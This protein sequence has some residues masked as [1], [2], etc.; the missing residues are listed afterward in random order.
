MTNRRVTDL[1]ETTSLDAADVLLVERVDANVTRKA[2]VATVAG[3]VGAQLGIATL[4]RI[5]SFD[6]FDDAIVPPWGITEQTTGGTLRR[7]ASLTAFGFPSSGAAMLRVDGTAGAKVTILRNA[8]LVLGADDPIVTEWK[9]S[10]INSGT[11]AVADDACAWRV[12]LAGTNGDGIL[13][14]AQLDP[15]RVHRL[16]SIV[17]GSPSVEAVTL[18]TWTEYLRIRLTVSVTGTLIEAGADGAALATI[19][20]V[21]TPPSESVYVPM[22]TIERDTGAGS[23]MLLLDYVR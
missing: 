19:E 23:R 20:T 17:G 2:N 15:G 7:S 4:E 12:G 18:P 11:A 21:A 1:T 3:A 14:A 22:A 8:G 6:D 10:V 16:V 9:L 5:A 13:L